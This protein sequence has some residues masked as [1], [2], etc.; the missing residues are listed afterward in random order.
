MSWS[1]RHIAWI[2]VTGL[3]VVGALALLVGRDSWSE[4]S[5]VATAKA[6]AVA[7]EGP[8]GIKPAGDQTCAATDES[9]K[10]Q[11]DFGSF[12]QNQAWLVN[13][14]AQEDIDALNA[15]LRDRFGSDQD[16]L[17]N[18]LIGLYFN[19]S[20]QVVEVVVDSAIV[21]IDSLR[22][23]IQGLP[24]DSVNIDVSRSCNRA[25]A[26]SD[27]MNELRKLG[28]ARTF[29]ESF[30]FMIDADTSTVEVS[31]EFPSELAKYLKERYGNLITIK[32]GVAMRL[33]RGGGRSEVRGK[34]ERPT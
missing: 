4:S 3:F 20:S 30:G 5:P 1:K 15:L 17:S 14:R 11:L 31:V 2:A 27:V 34:G 8:G 23:E 6:A 16:F 22:R 29:D 18:G 24:I 33:A 10:S 26:L 13:P 21:D 7:D 25:D 28:N 32:E 19:D 12:P 9:Q